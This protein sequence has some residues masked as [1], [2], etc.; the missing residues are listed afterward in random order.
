MTSRGS[1]TFGGRGHI[2]QKTDVFL[3]KERPSPGISFWVRLLNSQVKKYCSCFVER[4]ILGVRMDEHFLQIHLWLPDLFLPY[5]IQFAPQTGQ[6][7]WFILSSSET[8]LSKEDSTAFHVEIS[9]SFSI[10]TN[11]FC[12]PSKLFDKSLKRRTHWNFNADGGFYQL[13][14]SYNPGLLIVAIISLCRN[15]K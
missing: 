10:F 15:V 3:R 2:F 1:S 6:T 9:M 5:R 8:K 12:P 13:F 14:L 4:S 11:S 7:I